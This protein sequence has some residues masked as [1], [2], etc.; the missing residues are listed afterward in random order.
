MGKF[1]SEKWFYSYIPFVK[2]THYTSGKSTTHM[3]GG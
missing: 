2:I 3:E 1:I